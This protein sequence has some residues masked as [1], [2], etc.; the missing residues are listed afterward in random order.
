[1]VGMRAE[2]LGLAMQHVQLNVELEES[3][4]N[5]EKEA[6]TTLRKRD[7]LVKKVKLIK[8]G[9]DSITLTWKT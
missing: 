1:M 5:K 7:V 9:G 2:N 6:S 8:V 3:V 4:A